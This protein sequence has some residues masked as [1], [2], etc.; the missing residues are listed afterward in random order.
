MFNQVVSF[1]FQSRIMLL[2]K[3]ICSVWNCFYAKQDSKS[4]TKGNQSVKVWAS[5]H[6]LL[7]WGM[8]SST[9]QMCHCKQNLVYCNHGYTVD[10]CPTLY[11][12]S[13][14]SWMYWKCPVRRSSEL[15][16]VRGEGEPGEG[17]GWVWQALPFIKPSAESPFWRRRYACKC[18]STSMRQFRCS[19]PQNTC[20]DRW[21]DGDIVLIHGQVQDNSAGWGKTGQTRTKREIKTLQ[22]NNEKTMEN[23]GK[24]DTE[25]KNRNS[26]E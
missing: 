21:R 15:C 7:F 5:E 3:L 19:W 20:Q 24:V 14:E 9:E 8:Q 23:K 18:S 17:G 25:L 13:P 2:K 4:N 16:S 10:P 6:L 12:H 1:Y 26:D 11:K 22:E